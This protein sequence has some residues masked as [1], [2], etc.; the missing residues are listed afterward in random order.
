MR[1]QPNSQSKEKESNLHLETKHKIS[2]SYFNSLHQPDQDQIVDIQEENTGKSFIK[3]KSGIIYIG[4]A[5]NGKREGLGEQRW[6]D[7][8]TYEGEFKDDKA[9]GKGKFVHPDGDYYEGDWVNNKAEGIG[10]YTRHTGGYYKGGWVN[11]E[12]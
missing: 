11:D 1:S 2:V 7:G 9:N 4:E 8:A 6:P 12:P 5:K 10:R 3:Y